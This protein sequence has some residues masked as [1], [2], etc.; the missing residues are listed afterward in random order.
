MKYFLLTCMILLTYAISAQ[1]YKISTVGFYNLENLFD[2]IDQEGVHDTEFT[3]AGIKNWNSEKYQK[4]LHN[5]ARVISE[6]GT[7]KDKD[8]IDIL[9]VS[10]V[11]NASVL[12]DLVKEEAIA[13][14][15]YQIIHGDSRDFRGIDVALLFNPSYFL[16]DSFSM[17]DVPLYRDDGSRY[18][19]RDVLYVYGQFK[20]EPIH[21]FVNHWPSRRGGEAKSSPLREKA[22]S[23]VRAKTDEIMSKDND[24]KIIVMGDLNDDPTSPSVSSVLGAKQKKKKT[25]SGD[26]YNTHANFYHR[27]VGSNAYRDA[28]NLFDQV[29]ISESLLNHKEG[30]GFYSSGIFKKKYMLN[31]SGKYK[32]YPFR[33][34]SFDLFTN[35]YSDHFPSY[36]Y[37]IKEV[38]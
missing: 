9:G 18:Y 14:R 38:K 24:A 19:T 8:G 10:E 13:D 7:E 25:K 12:H 4:K 34:Y 21:L 6:I 31:P 2:T 11:E 32:G 1:E 30:Y 26:F 22:A 29:I 35:G 33:T 20:G 17:L 27:G 36:I 15:N 28:W 5:M 37:I 23:V 3:P 16:P